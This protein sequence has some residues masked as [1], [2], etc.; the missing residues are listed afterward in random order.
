MQTSAYAQNAT[1][2]KSA[3]VADELL[4]ANNALANSSI[5]TPTVFGCVKTETNTFCNFTN[6]EQFITRDNY[7]KASWC[8][9][10]VTATGNNSLAT[11]SNFI[12]NDK[13][14]L[15][16][17]WSGANLTPQTVDLYEMYKTAKIDV[18]NQTIFSQFPSWVKVTYYNVT[19]T[20]TAQLKLNGA[21]NISPNVNYFTS[22]PIKFDT[23]DTLTLSITG[24]A[25]FEFYLEFC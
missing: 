14:I 8:G 12:S 4:L 5:T 10:K 23:N 22:V 25:V 18:D 16:Y 11:F 17:V 6:I 15:S 19:N 21:T 7:I 24:N 2:V 20:G 9:F 13:Q 3:K 1:Q